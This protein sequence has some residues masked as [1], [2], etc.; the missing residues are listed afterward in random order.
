MTLKRQ[1]ETARHP[2][3]STTESCAENARRVLPGLAAE[4]FA[5]GRSLCD[6]APSPSDLHDFRLV[7]KRL[8]YS[9]ELFREHYDPALEEF[10]ASLR[11]VQRQLGL[12]SDCAATV[13]LLEEE[14][15][16]NGE[17]SRHL[18]TFL[19]ERQRA[20]ATEFLDHWKT[21]LDAPGE[22]E[23]WAGYLGGAAGGA[24]EKSEVDRK[25]QPA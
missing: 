23:A 11:T 7:G 8:R 15:L 12:V 2:E 16:T 5:L 14:G 25:P 6:G 24:A 21:R 22:A 17:D 4:Y 20:H 1:S 13:A 18:I 3:W 19:E 10:L 9:L